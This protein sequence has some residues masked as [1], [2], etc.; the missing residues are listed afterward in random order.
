[1][2]PIYIGIGVGAVAAV[3]IYAYFKHRPP[4]GSKAI[5]EPAKAEDEEMEIVDTLRYEDLLK[6]LKSQY[7]SKNALPGDAFVIAQNAVASK[8]FL[9]TFPNRTNE[10]KDFNCIAVSVVRGDEAVVAKF[11]LYKELASSLIDLLPKD[12]ETV[13]VQN[14]S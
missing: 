4:S 8:C 11:F 1:M 10:L 9:E 7:K 12:E 6:W 3:V 13:Y 2:T 5:Q 14:L